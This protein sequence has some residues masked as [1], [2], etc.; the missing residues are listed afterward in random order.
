MLLD[1]YK[2][3]KL[4]EKV[5]VKQDVIYDFLMDSLISSASSEQMSVI[6]YVVQKKNQLTIAEIEFNP[7]LILQT[8]FSFLECDGHLYYGQFTKCFPTF[9]IINPRDFKDR[10]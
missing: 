5:R 8:H 1:S 4:A 10:P 7:N 6:N 9:Y 3:F 2:E